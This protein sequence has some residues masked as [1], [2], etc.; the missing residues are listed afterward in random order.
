MRLLGPLH[1]ALLVA[2]AT[3]AGVLVMLCRRG[4]FRAGTVCTVLGLALGANEIAW[5]IWRY[6]R[7]GIHSGNL[8]LQLSDA[9]VWF[10]V[11]ACITRAKPA[12]EFTWFAGLAS[13]G[14]ALLTPDL[15]APWPQ[16]PAVYFFLAHGGVVMGAML[17]A[18]SGVMDFHPRSI[19]RPYL[20][21]LGW[22]GLAGCVDGLTGANYM[23]LRTKPASASAL[24]LLGPWPWYIV[25]SALVALGLF[26]LLWIPVR[27]GPKRSR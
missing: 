10:A 18:F 5:W 15:W 4:V 9:A 24:N 1:L 2:I 20:M 13:A 26:L 23:Y 27:P 3:I 12:A 25:T 8:P 17:V 6:S 19:W 16:W 11:T 22:A 7:E 21:L 14:M